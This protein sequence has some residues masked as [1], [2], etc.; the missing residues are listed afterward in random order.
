ME[1]GRQRLRILFPLGSRPSCADRGNR[2]LIDP[3]SWPCHACA[4][5]PRCILET[6][7]PGQRIAKTQLVPAREENL[8]NP[9]GVNN[10]FLIF[11]VLPRNYPKFG[12]RM[13]LRGVT[14]R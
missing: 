12:R 11:H 7:V 10:N 9:H 3:P 4:Q 2:A 1:R 14:K 6:G 5:S 8:G 13:A